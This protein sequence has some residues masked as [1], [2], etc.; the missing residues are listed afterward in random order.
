[1]SNKSAQQSQIKHYFWQVVEVIGMLMFVIIVCFT[2]NLTWKYIFPFAT[3]C[4]ATILILPLVRGLERLGIRR[5]LAVLAV[6][7]TMLVCLSVLFLYVMAAFI[8]EMKEFNTD[9][10]QYF[11]RT[12]TWI[13]HQFSQDEAFYGSLPPQEA[14][15]IHSTALNLL[16]SWEV[17]LQHF[18]IFLLRSATGLPNL[19]FILV[20]VIVATFFMLM[21]HERLY[22]SFLQILPPGWSEKMDIVIYDMIH[23]FTETVRIQA[24]L[25][26]MTASLGILGMLVTHIAYLV[27]LGVLFA[28][29]GCIPVFGSYFMTIPWA[30]GA[31][32][33]GDVSLGLKV[34]VIQISISIVRHLTE[35]K[36][37]A[38]SVRLDTLSTLFA[39]YVGMKVIGFIGVLVGP[40]VLIG[41]KS[42]FRFHLL[43]DF[44]PTYEDTFDSNHDGET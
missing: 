29:S 24:F 15:V 6:M 13:D 19:M 17:G 11:L 34:V 35:R 28:L 43:S 5:A 36:L 9:L 31:F 39:L 10:P 38:N 18:G 42:M 7:G 8:Q 37:L 40:I 12:R 3:A 20:I 22:Q 30:I 33:L 27:I 2:V 21:K 26:I 44:V 4:F 23:A 14:S 41:L 1:M 16:Q 25:A 32:I